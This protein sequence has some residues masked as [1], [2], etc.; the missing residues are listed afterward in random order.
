MI[1]VL[2]EV[3]DVGT[4]ST[5]LDY[6]AGGLSQWPCAELEPAIL[7]IEAP[8]S[9]FH[10]ARLAS[11]QDGSPALKQVMPIVRMDG[12]LPA[13]SMGLLDAEAGIAGPMS[14]D[15]VDLSVRLRSPHQSRKRIDDGAEV[16]L[17]ASPFAT[18]ASTGQC[19]GLRVSVDGYLG[20]GVQRGADSCGV[21]DTKV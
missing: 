2:P 19:A 6:L 16:V 4:C 15:E 20:V 3:V 9:R 8:Q 17:H 14:V 1:A 18:A 21:D 5:P 11:P 12:D 10:A 7:A 13:R